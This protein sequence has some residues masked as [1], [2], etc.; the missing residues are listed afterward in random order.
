MEQPI[1]HLPKPDENM[2]PDHLLLAPGRA[3]RTHFFLNSGTVFFR[4]F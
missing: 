1:P 2:P 3:M 4:S